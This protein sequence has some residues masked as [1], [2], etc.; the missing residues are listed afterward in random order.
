MPNTNDFSAGAHH[1]DLRAMTDQDPDWLIEQRE[2]EVILIKT[3]LD[4]YNQAKGGV[5]SAM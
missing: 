1:I 4:D 2:A 5:I 3:W